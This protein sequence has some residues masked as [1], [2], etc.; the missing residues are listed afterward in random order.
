M[1]KEN[2]QPSLFQPGGHPPVRE[3]TKWYK[4]TLFMWLLAPWKKYV[5]ALVTVPVIFSSAVFLL[6]SIGIIQ[7]AVNQGSILKDEQVKIEHFLEEKYGKDFVIKNG[8]IVNGGDIFLGF[9]FKTYKADVSPADDTDMVFTASRIVEGQTLDGGQDS[10]D[11]LNYSDNYLLQLWTFEL[12]DKVKDVVMSQP[13]DAFDV[14]FH[15]GLTKNRASIAEFYDKIWGRAP[16]YSELT[17]ELKQ[18]LT[19][20]SDI[21]AVGPI[22]AKKVEAYAATMIAVRD[23]LDSKRQGLGVQVNSFEIYSNQKDNKQLGKWQNVGFV[24]LDKVESINELTPYF[25]QWTNGYGKYYNPKTR[26][27][28]VS[29]PN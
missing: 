24:K 22:D 11:K 14:N 15:V 2:P 19:L 25:V 6:A 20:A 9:N 23:L 27:F 29:H 5:K 26:V 13:I 1:Q 12:Q 4:S 10:P 17:L 21:K 8:K 7:V 28:D 16:S 3:V 18:E